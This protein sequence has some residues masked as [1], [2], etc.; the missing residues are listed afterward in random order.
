MSLVVK[1]AWSGWSGETIVEL[2]DGTIWR[3]DE[4]VYEY[5][6]SYRPSV[7]VA[8]GRMSVAGMCRPVRVRRLSTDVRRTI[9][10]AWTG[11][12][13]KTIVEFTDGSRWEQAEYHYEYRYAYRPQAF[14]IDDTVLVEEMSKAV[15]VRRMR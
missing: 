15:R 14:L 4:Y 11:W 6:Y 7:S 2:S 13:G 5:R 9:D 8:D 12:D 3:Q 1:G 10:G